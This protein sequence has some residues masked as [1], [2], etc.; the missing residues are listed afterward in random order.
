MKTGYTHI[1]IILDRSGS[2]QDV[3]EATVAALNQFLEKQR[4]EK[5]SATVT[6]VQF[7]SQ[8]PYEVL[9]DFADIAHAPQ[10][11]MQTYV[12][13]ASTPLLDAMG[14]GIMALE[15]ALAHMPEEARPEFNVFVVMTDGM[16]NASREYTFD[17][18]AEMLKKKIDDDKWEVVYLSA[19]L[20]AVKEARAMGIERDRTLY[21]DKTQMRA[22]MDSV[23]RNVSAVR[24]KQKGRFN[25]DETDRLKS[26]Q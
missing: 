16:E 12:P 11:T 3:R 21:F 17:R 26:E 25:F 23:A 19:S 5:G 20:D 15:G 24:N 9:C 7:D 2:M 22:S 6:L 18:V 4:A 1:H 13:R 10:L 8:N 14:M